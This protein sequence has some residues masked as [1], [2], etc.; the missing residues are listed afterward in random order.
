MRALVTDLDRTLTGEDLRLDPRVPP[1]LDG[2][3]ARG[4]RV[5]VATGRTL[6]HVLALGLADHADLIVAENGAILHE[7]ATGA[8]THA[9][10]GFAA[11]CRATLGP[12]LAARFTW[13]EGLGS[14]PR[15]LASSSARILGAAA[16]PHAFAF[17]AEEVMLLPAGIDKAVGARRALERLGIAAA[18]AAAIGDGENDVT[19]LRLVGLGAAPANAHAAAR[20]AARVR[21]RGAYADGFLELAARLQAAAPR[22]AGEP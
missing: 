6:P 7:A 12:E 11:R 18:D 19:L 21:L 14:G 2:L 13:G 3:R 5:V 15:E 16:V 8:T 10:P 20:A 1:A 22:A 4:I 9:D 17:N